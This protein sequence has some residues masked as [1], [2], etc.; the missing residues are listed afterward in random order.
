MMRILKLIKASM[1][2]GSIISETLLSVTLSIDNA[3]AHKIMF[4]S[5]GFKM[6]LFSHSLTFLAK[7]MPFSTKQDIVK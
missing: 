6:T 7:Q 2:F 5:K 4:L 1:T 3:R